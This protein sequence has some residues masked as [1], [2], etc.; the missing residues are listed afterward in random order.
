M[1][2]EALLE[3]E[4]EKLGRLQ[5]A[6]IDTSSII[7]LSKSELLDPLAGLIR[8]VTVELVVREAGIQSLPVDV[9]ATQQDELDRSPD[10]DTA[11]LLCALNKGIPLLSEDRKLLMRAEARGVPYY[12]SIMMIALMVLRGAIDKKD[13]SDYRDRLVEVA[14]YGRR[15]VEYG[16]DLI[17]YVVMNR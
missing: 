16:D 11:I 2:H 9:V 8:L 17:S 15:V 7:Y 14:H 4:V 10:A 6:A 3:V 12:N 5:R 13:V 1:T